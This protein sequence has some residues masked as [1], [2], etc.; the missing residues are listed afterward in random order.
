MFLDHQKMGRRNG[1]SLASAK[2][3]VI[4]F[5]VDSIRNE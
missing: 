4:L 1:N 2:A 5:V 3:S